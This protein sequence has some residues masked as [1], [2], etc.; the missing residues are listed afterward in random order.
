MRSVRDSNPAVATPSK[1]RGLAG[2]KALVVAAVVNRAT[3]D[4]SM[5]LR[6]LV[7]RCGVM[8]T[9]LVLENNYNRIV[10]LGTP[11]GRPCATLRKSSYIAGY[12]H[13]ISKT[14]S[15]QIPEFVSG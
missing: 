9:K 2:V 6:I 7:S 12:E 4:T 14:T 15:I 3:F 11:Y 8:I 1:E 10:S 13:P 5:Y